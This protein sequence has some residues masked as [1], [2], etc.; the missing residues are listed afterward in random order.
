MLLTVGAV[1]ISVGL[2]GDRNHALIVGGVIAAFYLT[3]IFAYTHGTLWATY[4]WTWTLSLEEQFYLLWPSILR[5]SSG[6]IRDAR[7]VAFGTTAVALVLAEI[8]ARNGVNGQVPLQ[9]YQPQA[10]AFSLM[11]GCAAAMIEVPRWFRH[12]ALPALLGILA[13]GQWSDAVPTATFLRVNTPATAVLTVVLILGLEHEPK[14]ARGI[15]GSAPI[16]RIG[17]ISY[18]L[19]LYHPIVYAVVGSHL[20]PSSHWKL[21]V[22]C[23]VITYVVAE[24]SFRLYESPIRRHGRAWLERRSEVVTPVTPATS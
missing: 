15:L 1:A 9:Y 16:A 17:V 22:V 13:L 20:H 5:R 11:L 23:A 2:P 4:V 18:G 3:D 14:I 19:Y 21:V 10:H 6:S 7:L 24:L 8:F 12:L